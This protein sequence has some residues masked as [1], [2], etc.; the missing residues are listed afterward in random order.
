MVTVENQPEH[1]TAPARLVPLEGDPYE[2][3]AHEQRL[4]GLDAAPADGSGL[5]QSGKIS[6]VSG[7][8]HVFRGVGFPPRCE[9]SGTPVWMQGA[10]AVDRR[11]TCW[12]YPRGK[13]GALR[14]LDADAQD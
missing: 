10:P 13:A 14:G 3:V 8:M 5:P 4:A 7:T 11:E 2:A 6:R 9:L 1:A 12:S